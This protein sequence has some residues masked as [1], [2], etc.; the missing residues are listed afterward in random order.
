MMKVVV[1]DDERMIRLG[2]KAMIERKFTETDIMLA[3][4]GIEA[5]ELCRN[6]PIDLVIT[7]I[8]MP[9]MDG[10]QLIEELQGI[11]IP[12]FV[13]ILS[14]YDDFSY[15]KQ[16]IQFQVMDYL[17]KPVDR[18]ELFALINKAKDKLD[19][20]L[21]IQK[22]EDEYLVNQLNYMLLNPKMNEKKVEEAVR[23][24]QLHQYSSG[25]YA[26]IFQLKSNK[27]TLTKDNFFQHIVKQIQKYDDVSL[28]FVD[29]YE[30]L[31]VFTECL[32]GLYVVFED[33]Q[34]DI[35]SHLGVGISDKHVSMG[36]LVEAYEQANEA[37]V[38][39]FIFPHQT[40]L[41]YEQVK[42][43]KEDGTIVNKQLIQKIFNML[44]T[45]RNDEI[46]SSLLNIF[47]IEEMK[48]CKIS[49][50]E[51]LNEA[52]NR[53]LFDQAFNQIGMESIEVFKLYDKVGDMSNFESVYDYF[54]A[55]ENLTIRLH[56]YMKEMKSVYSGENIMDKAIE[57]IHENAHKDLNM[58]VVSNYVSLNY[59]YFS[60][61]F[62]DYTGN[63]FVD[64]LKK[65]RI[66]KAK[67]LLS[68]SNHKIFEVSEL[69]GFGNSKQF[70]RVFR[71]L[72]GVSPKEY[73]EKL[74]TERT[75]S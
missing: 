67:K 45:N 51:R 66:E 17:L 38:Y 52:I 29:S 5:L 50:L 65:V 49:C 60:H 54:Y 56:E 43:K 2:I 48:E 35:A 21:S 63:N 10:I 61:A 44:G 32:E 23:K 73:R 74:Y 46:R 12:P 75:L 22:D 58:A 24:F 3:S 68:D 59:S 55:V 1:V 30:N 71:D 9:H 70:S 20:K 34:F 8:K 15:A 40:I 25:F 14:G 47:N 39:R 41:T 37:L 11:E 7:D 28:C 31:V 42:A 57:F 72:E 64:Y 16:A 36:K 53:V 69:V 62:K 19:A 27:S 13:I 26:G 18:N 6:N 4:D 33:N